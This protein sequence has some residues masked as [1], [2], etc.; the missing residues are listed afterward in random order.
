MQIVRI[1]IAPYTNATLSVALIAQPTTSAPAGIADHAS[2][3]AIERTRESSLFGTI[4]CRRLPVLMLK[5]IPR[6]PAAPHSGTA[7]QYQRM[8]EN[9]IVQAPINI[10]DVIARAV[11]L[12][13]L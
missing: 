9:A 13:R 11:K 6:P 3:P 10:S 8:A 2:T 7:A 5:R 12:K 4:A 1:P